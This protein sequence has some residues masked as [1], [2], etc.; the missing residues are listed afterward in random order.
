[1]VNK[2]TIVADGGIVT[3]S[4]G[5]DVFIG[6]EGGNIMVKVEGAASGKGGVV[7]SGSINA[8]KGVV[9]M[10]GA[11]DIYSIAVNASALSVTR[12]GTQIAVPTRA[13]VEEFAAKVEDAL[14]ATSLS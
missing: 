10:T 11:G 4:S 14:A 7:N 1:M 12:L 8:G 3:M 5:K 13:E 6:E 9:R 2:G